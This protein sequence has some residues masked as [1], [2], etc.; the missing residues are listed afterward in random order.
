MCSVLRQRLV[1]ASGF[2]FLLAW[3]LQAQ[4]PL[5]AGRVVLAGSR[6]RHTSIENDRGPLDSS[7]IIGGMSL[8]FRRSAAQ[9]ADLT[10]LLAEQ[11]DPSSP[12][13]HAWLTPDSYADRFGLTPADLAKVTSWLEAEGLRV[14]YVSRSRTRVMFSGPVGQVQSAFGTEIHRYEVNGTEHF[15][16]AGDPSIPASLAP[17][18][19]LVR[20]LDDFRTQPPRAR[21]TPVPDFTSGGSHFLTPGDV[22]TIYDINALYQDGFTGSGQKIAVVGQTDI[23]M[24]D[25]EMFRTQFGLPT[26]NPEL[27]LVTG[28]PDP[29]VSPDDLIESSL[30]LEYAGGIAPNASILFVYSTDVWNSVAYAVDEDLAPVIST[31]YGGCEPDISSWPAATG[32]Y[33]QSIAQQA[34]ALGITWLAASGDAGAAA[35]DI[36]SGIDAASQGLAVNLPASVPEVTAMGGTQF[37]EGSG[38]Y[39]SSTNNA[40][41]SS[42]LSY[43]PEVAWND[44]AENI[45][46]GGGLAATGGGA[47][48]LFSKPSWQTGTGVPN[49]GVRDV[50]DISFAAANDHDPYLIYADGELFYVGGTSVSTP[51]FSGILALVNQYFVSN[52]ILSQAGLGNVNPTLYHLSQTTTGVFHDITA[53]NNIV[54]CVSGSPNCTNG[55]LGYNAGTGYDQTT[56]L[57]SLDA[58]NLAI[59]WAASLAGPTATAVVANPT[60]FAPNSSTVLTATVSAASGTTS[61]TGSVSFMV[62]STLLGT[63]ALS[64]SG[65]SATASLTVHGSQLTAGSNLIEASYGGSPAFQASSGSATVNVNAG[66]TSCSYSLSSTSLSVGSGSGSGTVSVAAA[67]GCAWTA[68]SDALWLTISAG[69]S[70]NGDGT[71]DYSFAANLGGVALTGTLT[72][73]GQSFTITQSPTPSPLAFYTLTPCRIA[74]TRTGSGFSGAFG[75]PALAANTTRN[76]PIPASSCNVPDTAQAYSLNLGALPEA[77]LGFLTAWPAGVALP[78]VGTLG[79]PTGGSVSNAALVPAGTTGA[80]SVFANAASN[81]IIDVNGYFA[82]TGQAHALAFYPIPPCR[83]ADTRTG[84]GFSGAF[85][86]PSLSANVTRTLPMPSSACNLPDTAQAYSLNFGVIP[87]APLG[88]LTTWPAGSSLPQVG[89]LGSPNGTPVSNAA[90]VAAG[91][92]AA[93]SLDANAQTDVIVDSNGY[94]AAPGGAGA[95]FFYPMTPCRIAD[96][97]TVGSGLMGAFGPPT[98]SGGSTRNFPIPSSDCGVPATALAYSLNIGVVT[99]GPLAYLTAWPAGQSQPVV[100]TLSS[101]GAG[102]VSDAAI[103]PAGTSG[104]ISI[105]VADTTDVIIDINGYF[106]Q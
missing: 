77:P 8:V 101:Q 91:T 30:D 25:I 51:V 90:L 53:G 62:G 73:A 11:R 52:G 3:Q 36:G 56:G 72:I 69:S 2:V 97:R 75:A 12:G 35:C 81:L 84:S 98:M 89:T 85:G 83:V 88:F 70:G 39:W 18:V 61:P 50:P 16:N 1:L 87:Y 99:P 23:Y 103:V 5:D 43:I 71:V 48:I 17:L 76:F 34:N 32:A 13:Y 65:G 49:D 57:G 9:S 96:T 47:S 10:K 58:N 31:S 94:F 102:V 44:S 21:V 66:Q 95:L 7:R 74:D 104:A 24:S 82:P 33:F 19:W 100:G 46:A 40:N 93:I 29:G 41:R 78:D 28:S 79:S 60:S 4:D 86:A 64:G 37:N 38:V 105:F 68:S 63:G 14:D 106:A 59:R 92:S 55:Q 26:N 42:A 27:V 22:A 15:A 80:I 20:G 54:P 45:S 67:A 6:S